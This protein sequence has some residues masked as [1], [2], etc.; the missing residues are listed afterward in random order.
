MEKFPNL[1]GTEMQHRSHS[2]ASSGSIPNE[3]TGR[4]AVGSILEH[5]FGPNE[6]SYFTTSYPHPIPH[7]LHNDFRSR[8][9]YD[10]GLTFTV[11]DPLMLERSPNS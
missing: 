9:W 5:E 6:K 3:L 2:D 8:E 1:T 4:G 11:C 10:L 7:A